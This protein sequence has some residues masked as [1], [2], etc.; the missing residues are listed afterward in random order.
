MGHKA[1]VVAAAGV[2]SLAVLSFSIPLGIGYLVGD[3]E[4]GEKTPTSNPAEKCVGDLTYIEAVSC[5]Q[6]SKG[7]E[8]LVCASSSCRR[9]NPMTCPGP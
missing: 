5:W 1:A 4:P 2:L 3:W 8:C 6:G 7:P 9:I